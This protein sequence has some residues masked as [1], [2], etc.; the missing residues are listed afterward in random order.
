MGAGTLEEARPLGL[1]DRGVR[2]AARERED[3]AH[4]S[5]LGELACVLGCP[6]LA[7]DP[8]AAR[9]VP[10]PDV[11]LLRVGLVMEAELVEVPEIDLRGD[12]ALLGI[13]RV[14]EAL[15]VEKSATANSASALPRSAAAR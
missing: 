9:G 6:G 11:R 5:E 1:V 2:T 4:A 12:A 13:A 7:L 14:V 8:R 10:V 15:F 3:V